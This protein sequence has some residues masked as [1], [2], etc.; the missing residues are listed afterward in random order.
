[1]RE[2]P[3]IRRPAGTDKLNLIQSKF[4]F[5]RIVTSSNNQIRQSYADEFKSVVDGTV[6]W[7][8][9]N[10]AGGWPHRVRQRKTIIQP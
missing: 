6:P 9:I 2:T 10:Y 8:F 3:H 1:M 4:M 5:Q 7:A